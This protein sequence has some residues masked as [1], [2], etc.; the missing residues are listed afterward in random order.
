MTNWAVALSHIVDIGR[1]AD[2]GMHKPRIR[3]DANVRL[4]AEVPLVTLLG[5][6]H[7]GVS[8]A[9]AVLSGAGR[10]NQV[11]ID[12]GT[13]FT[14]Q[15]L[16]RQ[17]GVDGGPQLDAQV[18]L[19]EQVAESQDGRLVGQS[20]AARVEFDKLAIQ[21]DVMQGIFHIRIAQ[22][23]PLLQEVGA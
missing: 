16:G 22:T 13:N 23:K 2:D 5:L 12:H 4:H 18:F 3:V 7:I 15:T 1:C 20:H 9:R 11:G 14:H 8:L 21:R 6:V 19:F 10:G 17:G